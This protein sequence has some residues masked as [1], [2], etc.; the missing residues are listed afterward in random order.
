MTWWNKLSDT[1]Q[2]L[3]AIG[4]TL[5][6]GTSIG[7]ASALTIDSH[8]DLPER[9]DVVEAK[10]IRT[11]SVVHDLGEDMTKVACIT[12]KQLLGED[13]LRCLLPR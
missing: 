12:E 13:A 6:F 5:A 7:A 9:M 11:D 4:F 2:A 1:K 8:A 3:W 10:Q